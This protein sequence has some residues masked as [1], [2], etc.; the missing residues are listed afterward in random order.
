MIANSEKAGNV[1]KEETFPS[2]I[3]STGCIKDM[4]VLHSDWNRMISLNITKSGNKHN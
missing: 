3:W 1:R 2:T 4:V